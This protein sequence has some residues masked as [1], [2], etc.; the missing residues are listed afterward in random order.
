[1]RIGTY[2]TL[3]ISGALL[4]G[5][6][7]AGFLFLEHRKHSDLTQLASSDKLFLKDIARLSDGVSVVLLNTDQIL[8]ADNEF[9]ISST[10]SQF[11][12]LIKLCNDRLSVLQEAPMTELKEREFFD[13]LL[14]GSMTHSAELQNQLV[15]DGLSKKTNNR[16]YSL[17]IEQSERILRYKFELVK[18]S[19]SRLRQTIETAENYT[20]SETQERMANLNMLFEQT[21]KHSDK[22]FYSTEQLSLLGGLLSENSETVLQANLHKSKQ[23]V[24]W[25]TT[26]YLF[27]L[28]LIWAWGQSAISKPLK[29]LNT[30]ARLAENNPNRQLQVIERGPKEVIELELSVYSFVTSLEDARDDAV[31]ASQMKGEFLANMSHEL[32]TPLNAIIGYSEMLMEDAEDLGESLFV[33]DLRKID[34]AGKHLLALISDILDLSK[35]EAGK[36]ELYEE[37]FSVEALAEDV[38]TTI[39]SLVA[40]N[41]NQFDLKVSGEVNVIHADLTKLRQILFNLIS[42]SAKFTSSGIITLAI[43]KDDVDIDSY[44]VFSV[45]DT[46]IGMTE[47]HLERLFEKFVQADSSTTR[48]YGGTGLGLSLCQEFAR[49]MQGELTV[50]STIDVGTEFRLRIPTK[51]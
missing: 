42:N 25:G 15:S 46:G 33:D 43:E 14:D 49:L 16:D 28:F 37:D 10:K 9:I 7:L 40:K 24:V 26:F 41:N 44:V 51:T 31:K 2:L 1:M 3:I 19:L 50:E 34:N 12:E 45:I 8:G 39:Q 20:F 13:N 6:A 5:L 30:L 35:I 11:T 21:I 38:A 36:M 18:E 48:K 27:C 47:E 32:R 22:L 17:L 23:S 29:A 4:G